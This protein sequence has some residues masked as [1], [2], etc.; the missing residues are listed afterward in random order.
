MPINEIERQAALNQYGILDTPSDQR[1][2]DIVLLASLLFNTPIATI[3]LIDRDREWFKAKRGIQVSCS[4]RDIAFCAHGILKKEPLII[5]DTM[6]DNRFVHN[7]MVIGEPYIRFYAGVPL[8]SPEGYALGMLC[9]KDIKPRTV[10]TTQIEG[11]YA[12]SRR[13]MSQFDLDRSTIHTMRMMQNRLDIL[14]QNVPVIFLS[15]DK[16]GTIRILEGSILPKIG[17]NREA[18]I[19]KSVYSL[20]KDRQEIIDV[21]DNTL[22]GKK[23]SIQFVYHNVVMNL[24]CIPEFSES[25]ELVGANCVAM[26]VTDVAS[27]ERE[28]SIK[29]KMVCIGKLAAGIAHEIN[30][31]L[32]YIN[33]NISFIN[34]CFKDLLNIVDSIKTLLDDA[35]TSSPI[36]IKRLSEIIESNDADYICTEMPKAIHDTLHGIRQVTDIAQALKYFTHTNT[37]EQVTKNLP[38]CIESVVTISRNE[39]KYVADMDLDLTEDIPP[40]TGNPNELSQVILNL[41]VNSSYAITEAGLESKG[42]ITISV[43]NHKDHV[44]IAVTDNGCGV[45]VSL[46]ERIFDPF[47]TTKPQ[48]IGTGQG[49][50][51]SKTVITE[52][53]GGTMKLDN[54]Y[55]NGARFIITLPYAHSK[56]NA[57]DIAA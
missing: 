7:P 13:V 38:Q 25:N 43:R 49:L 2:D 39:W 44:E 26:D 28:V 23:S 17:I 35:Q 37:Q 41:I 51:F 11:L 14:L 21:L 45:P 4:P 48:G 30:S 3:S 9:V 29:H 8:I 16:S 47:F 18:Y 19:N 6:R 22:R 31:P 52:H 56:D 57:L 1:Y 33:G 55:T 40:V 32:Q 12:L 24:I 15:M 46:R 42:F 53:A 50:S 20:F 27:H 10:K 5:P 54:K 34:E 36:N